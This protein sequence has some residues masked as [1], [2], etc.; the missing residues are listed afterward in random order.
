LIEPRH[1]YFKIVNRSSV[2]PLIL[3]PLLV[4]AVALEVLVKL[5]LVVHVHLVLLQRQRLFAS[6][7]ARLCL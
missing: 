2:C 6:F 5:L 7:L 4:F 1:F 3:Q